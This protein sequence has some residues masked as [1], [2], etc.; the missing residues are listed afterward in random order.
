MRYAI[1]ES[2]GK[3]FRVSE[4]DTIRVPSIDAEVGNQVEMDRVLLIG[5]EAETKLGTPLIE[6]SKVVAEVLE[7]GRGPKIIVYKFKRRK[8]YRRKQG[9]R[10]N[11]TKVRI[12]AIH[13]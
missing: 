6:G 1:I 5:G 7:H 12:Q 9:H 3:Q 2:G 10:Q 4:G 13:V 8:Q 11:F